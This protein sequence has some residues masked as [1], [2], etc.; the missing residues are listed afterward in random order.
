MS[1]NN[2]LLNIT[3]LVNF[4]AVKAH[5]VEP[6][7]TY[8]LEEA[9]KTLAKVTAPETPTTWEAV[10]IPLGQ[11]CERMERV[12]GTASHLQSV[13]DTPELRDV[14]NKMLPVV[15]A[16]AI[17]ASQ[18]LDLMKKY[19]EIRQSKA[20]ESLSPVR[21][22]LIERYLR[23]F[24]LAG[25]DLPEDKRLLVKDIGEKLAQ[26]SQKFSENLL[27]ATYAWSL[28][29]TDKAELDGIP[30]TELAFLG[31]SAQAA[32]EEGWR[33]TPH[34]PSYLPIMQYANNRALREK[35]HRAFSTRASELGDPA[36]DNTPLIDEILALRAQESALLGF[37]TYAHASLATKMA[38]TPEEVMSFL[39]DIAQKSRPYAL[40][41]MDDLKRYAKDELGLDE[42][43]PWDLAWVSEKLRQARYSYSDAEVRQYFTEPTVFAGLFDL[44]Q[45][46]YGLDIREAK[47]SVW[48]PD[49]KF[50]EIY[51]DGEKIAGFYADLYARE[52]KRQGAWMND[53]R[54]REL[55]D[56]KIVTPTAFLICNFAHGV[57]GEP[58]TLNHDDVVTLFHE[59]G[60]CLHH[61]LTT[62]EESDVSGINGVEWDAV[63]LPSQF[64]ENFAWEWAVVEKLT[65]HVKTGEPLP[66]ELFDK[67]LAAKNYHAGLASL[68]QI[69]F[70]L[71]DMVLHTRVA[72]NVMDV[73][74]EVRDEVAVVKAADYSRFPQS[75]S[76]IFAGG[77]SA[78]YYSYKWAEVLSADAFAAFEETGVVN[79]ETGAR[80]LKEILSRG[81]SRDAMD[82]F[83]AFRGRRPSIEPLL[84]HSGMS[85]P[86]AK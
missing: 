28:T 67:M 10:T 17:E 45:K 16:F 46:L 51:K 12:W 58:A 38:E 7:L 54:T 41:D 69:E 14:V 37:K 30:E 76:H 1:D 4:Q 5:H 72:P 43:K 57:N 64:M 39:R 32:G 23:D 80:F 71:F 22:R 25:A 59:F 83:I 33:V 6:A 42:I 18:N 2:P 82:N 47:A 35:V 34:Y 52:G 3:D 75:F 19:Q 50:F 61:L 62:Q 24:H 65:R 21:Q 60:H 63:E 27:D 84:R 74:N 68:R 78:G 36:L 9:K 11:A 66:R 79:P 26:L 13:V 53:D 48:H 86:T 70:A 31:A 8:Y 73:L 15:S 20:F 40:K 29:I 44:A 55:K 56:G 85:E 77:Y 81:S 49:V